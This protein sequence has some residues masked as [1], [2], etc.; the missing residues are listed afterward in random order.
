MNKFKVGDRVVQDFNK[1]HPDDGDFYRGEVVGI[2]DL[3]DHLF[4]KWDD[5]WGFKDKAEEVNP[6][7]ILLECE[8][9]VK[10]NKL[11]SEYSNLHKAILEKI[12]IAA[13]LIND[14]GEIAV[15][16]GRD[17]IDMYDA[18]RPLMLALDNNGWST[19]SMRC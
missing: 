2:N 19:S 1:Y 13:E 9:E 14:A 11:E 18:V 5:K 8:G 17:L 16:G 15:S 3:N 6:S 7:R 10:L 12:N 4:V